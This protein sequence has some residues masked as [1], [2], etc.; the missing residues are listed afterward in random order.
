MFIGPCSTFSLKRN[1]ITSFSLKK[2]EKMSLEAGD[3]LHR[4]V[5]KII[6]RRQ[7][8]LDRAQNRGQRL[9]S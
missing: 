1:V 2:K 5:L 8:S 4:P 6:G 7:I 3:Y 9:S